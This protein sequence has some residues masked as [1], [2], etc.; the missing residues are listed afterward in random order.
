[1]SRRKTRSLA[2]FPRAPVLLAVATLALLLLGESLLLVRSDSGQI[3]LARFLG[4]GDPNRVTQ[5]V[6]KQLRQAIR[7]INVPED[8]VRVSVAERGAPSLVW[9]GGLPPPAPPPRAHH[10]VPPYL[11]QRGAPAPPGRGA[12][13]GGVGER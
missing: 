11:R 6:S 4:L 7:T 13:R 8:S 9:R 3:A 10:L 5:I 12:E 2:S 1:M